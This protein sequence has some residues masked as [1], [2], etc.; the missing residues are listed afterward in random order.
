MLDALVLDDEDLDPVELVLVLVVEL[1]ADDP[2][3]LPLALGRL[4]GAMTSIVTVTVSD[5]TKPSKTW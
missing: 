1:L 2:E 3:P 5:N 4:S